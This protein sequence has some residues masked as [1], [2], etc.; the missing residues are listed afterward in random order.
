ME[1]FG[2]GLTWGE[3]ALMLLPLS[4]VAAA[5]ILRDGLLVLRS[6]GRDDA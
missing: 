1:M 2:L 5:V 6:K 4:I 3:A